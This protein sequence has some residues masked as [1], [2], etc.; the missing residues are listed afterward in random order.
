MGPFMSV[1]I[2]SIGLV[3]L[4]AEEAGM[5]ERVLFAV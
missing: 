4:G 5:E 3:H 2:S 1:W